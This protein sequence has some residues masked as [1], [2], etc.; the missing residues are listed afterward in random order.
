MEVIPAIDL[1]GGACVRLYQGDFDRETVFSR[2]PLDVAL[3]WEQ[4][5]ATRL[6]IVDLDGSREG[7]L[8]NLEL[9]RSI[10][11]RS[12]VP[13]Q[14]GGGIRNFDVALSLLD[15]GIDRIVLGTAAVED[16]ELVRRLCNERGGHRIVVAVDARDG[17]VAIKGWLEETSTKAIKLAMQM[18]E[19]GAQRLLCTDIGRDGTMSSPD[20]E[21]IENMVRETGIEILAS[22]GVSTLEQVRLL[23]EMGAEGVVLGSA[24]YRGDLTLDKAMDAAKVG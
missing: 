4:Y 3:R 9:I 10:S 1:R 7:S 22:G 24:L 18:V 2:D 21:G 12:E 17:N 16:P 8:V 13:L 6:H 23:A 5:G 19:M 15:A 11:V 14:V 20:F